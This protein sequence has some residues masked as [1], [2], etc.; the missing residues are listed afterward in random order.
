M[1][2]TVFV[3]KVGRKKYRAVTSQPVPLESEGASQEEAVERL[4][5]LATD[6]LAQGK[7]LQMEL[8]G[9]SNP[10]QAFAG[11]WKDHPEFD[12]FLENIAEYRRDVDRSERRR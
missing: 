12:A 7:L 11:M 3:E 8:P 1:K 10:W 9:G 4:R 6:R 2:T 5:Q